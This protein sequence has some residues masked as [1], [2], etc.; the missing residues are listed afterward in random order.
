MSKIR[1]E[2]T[3]TDMHD[4]NVRRAAIEQRAKW[5]GAFYREAKADGIDLEPIMRRAIYKIGVE[6]GQAEAKKLD[7]LTAG[8]Y[9]RYFC[10]KAL[11]ETFEKKIL[12]DGEDH[13]ECSLNYCP[14]VKAWQKMGFSDE[15]CA[16]LCDIAMDGDRGIAE[17]LGL[18][19]EL[20]ST[21]ARGDDCCHLVYDNKK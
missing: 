2:A 9:G 15:E 8:S 1:N 18:D 10:T 19:F 11:H 20:K 5:A 21:I 3:I 16:L 13:F 6:S 17:G 4:N 14:L 7:N 12:V